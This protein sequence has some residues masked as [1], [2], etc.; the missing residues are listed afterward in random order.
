MSVQTALPTHEFDF[1]GSRVRIL[2]GGEADV[3]LVDMIEVPAGHMPPLHV[4]HNED[5]GFYLLSGEATLFMPGEQVT[6]RAGDFFLAPGGVPHAYRVGDTPARW[7]IIS[8]PAG[9]ERFVAEVGEQRID[10]PA[11]LAEAAARHDIEIL[12]PPGMLP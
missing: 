10:D 4:H 12:G 6:L 7:L 9:F 11:A 3:G 5:E 8:S 2:A 1:L